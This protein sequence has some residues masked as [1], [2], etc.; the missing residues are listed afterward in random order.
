MRHE[1]DIIESLELYC[2]EYLFLRVD[3]L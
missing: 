2:L 3:E 1:Y